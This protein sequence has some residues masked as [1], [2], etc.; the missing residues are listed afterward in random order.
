MV[1]TSPEDNEVCVAELNDSPMGREDA[2]DRDDIELTYIDVTSL[3]PSV[4]FQASRLHDSKIVVGRKGSGKTHVLLHIEQ[5]SRLDNREVAY[6]HLDRDIFQGRGLLPYRGDRTPEESVSLWTSVWRV[7]LSMAVMSRFTARRT[8]QRARD[9]VKASL[10]ALDLHNFADTPRAFFEE[11]RSRHGEL[12]IDCAGPRSPIEALDALTKKYKNLNSLNLFLDT[13]VNLSGIESDLSTLL[14][15]FGPI[16]FIIDG[17]DEYAYSDPKGWL[18]LQVGLFSAAFE[19]ATVRRYTQN[20][21]LTISLRNYVFARASQTPHIDR[22]RSHILRLSWDASSAR[23]FLNQRLS[24]LRGGDF[25][26]SDELMGQRPLAKWLGFDSIRSPRRDESEDVEQYLLR[27]SRLSPRNLVEVFNSLCREQNYLATVGQRIDVGRFRI[28]VEEEARAVAS[29]MLKVAAE[30]IIALVPNV[31][32]HPR[33]SAEYAITE[34]AEKISVCVATCATETI[35]R[36]TC[37]LSLIEALAH[38]LGIHQDD[39]F[40]DLCK[41]LEAALWRSGL[42][43]YQ[44]HGEGTPSWLFSW[45]SSDLGPAGHAKTA[46]RIGFHSCLIAFCSLEVSPDGPVF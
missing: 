30:E 10:E 8:S 3:I 23:S 29:L 1:V 2:K 42:F 34:I 5:L 39:R 43:A 4:A 31:T 44:L 19:L 7:S 45:A 32:T 24:Q 26:R 25:A 6:S 36:A 16:H 14:H 20:L 41:E 9:A 12:I 17:L 40:A 35:D 33:V 22:A 13:E 11:M 15:N 21:K 18:D 27:H 28:V 38:R 37:T 46:K